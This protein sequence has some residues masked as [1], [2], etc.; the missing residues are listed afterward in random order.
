MIEPKEVRKKILS[1]CT[2]IFEKINTS[3]EHGFFQIL[4][5]ISV[6]PK[7]FDP[8]TINNIIVEEYKK[9]GWEVDLVLLPNNISTIFQFTEIKP[10]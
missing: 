3:L 8:K 10:E 1:V 2:S 4:I 7:F 5:D 6:Y 9:K